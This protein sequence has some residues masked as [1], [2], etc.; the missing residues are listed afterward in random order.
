MFKPSGCKQVKK[1]L[2][3]ET[4]EKNPSRT[5]LSQ[6]NLNCQNSFLLQREQSECCRT[7]NSPC[8]TQ[9]FLGFQP[10]GNSGAT[11]HGFTIMWTLHTAAGVFHVK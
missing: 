6:S 1:P 11:I 7:T 10:H 5:G 9:L 2:L 8:P 3:R 4:G